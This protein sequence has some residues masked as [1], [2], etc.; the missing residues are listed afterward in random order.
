MAFVNEK[1]TE[2]Q[3]AEFEA[4]GIKN[5]TVNSIGILKPLYWTI[6]HEDNMCLVHAGVYRDAWYEH[7]FVFFWKDE[8]HIISL[9]EETKSPNTVIWKKEKELSPYIFSEKAPFVKDLK[10]ALKVYKFW[11]E[12]EEMKDDSNVII[13]F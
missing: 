2:E 10:E 3:R 4:R 5:P 6:N 13:K 12:P 11:G 8:Q 9:F 7:Y 1:L